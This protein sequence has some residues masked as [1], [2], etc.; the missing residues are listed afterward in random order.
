MPSAYQDV[1][2]THKAD[3]NE[4]IAFTTNSIGKTFQGCGGDTPKWAALLLDGIHARSVTTLNRRVGLERESIVIVEHNQ[5][6]FDTL[7]AN[8][9]D[10]TLV[11]DRMQTYV[12]D[13]S[14]PDDEFNIVFFDWMCTI[15][16]NE[17]E[18]PP[19]QALS[20]YLARTKLPFV[21]VAQT[22]CLRGQAIGD[23]S[24]PY[25]KAKDVVCE[26]ITK[27]AT[28][29][30]YSPLWN[31]YFESVYT[32]EGGGTAMFFCC[33]VLAHVPSE[34]SPQYLWD[35]FNR[36]QLQLRNKYVKFSFAVV[37]LYTE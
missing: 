6:T 8:H 4:W 35:F 37:A 30:G 3:N 33:L 29:N 31:S 7:K 16:G 27:R 21:V 24:Q 34:S 11:L 13:E 15:P 17:Q 23:R 36:N 26:E 25:Q 14:F 12:R 2:S 28:L 22:F 32:R 19:L 10:C 1:E 18:G 20:D 9:P 5:E